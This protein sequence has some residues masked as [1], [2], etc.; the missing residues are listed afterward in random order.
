MIFDVKGLVHPPDKVIAFLRYYPSPKG[1]RSRGGQQYDKVY[2]LSNRFDFLRQHYPQYLYH[3]EVFGREL[4]GV[5]HSSIKH[6]YQPQASLAKLKQLDTRDPLQQD[7]VT[8]SQLIEQAARIPEES[9]GISGSV[10]V[11]LHGPTSDIDLIVYGRREARAVQLS[12][13]RAQLVPE[14]G[15]SKYHLDTYRPVYNLR[16]SGTGIPIETMLLVDGLKS[17]HGIFGGHHYFVRAVLNWDQ[18]QR[19][20]GDYTFHPLGQARVRCIITDDRDGLFTPCRY[21]IEDVEFL[22]GEEWDEVREIVSFRGRFTEQVRQDEEVIV[23]G[24][25]EA[26]QQGK[27]QWV[28]FVLGDHPS[29]ILLPSSLL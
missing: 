16:W 22:K 23:Q 18:V 10:Q 14:E 17:M 4:Q 24:S 28:R 25:L 11:D 21:E 13:K 1:K 7:V 19:Q 8:F 9:L 20:Y 26:V 2:H 29:D 3:D 5:P 15:I 6:V 12:L 27:E